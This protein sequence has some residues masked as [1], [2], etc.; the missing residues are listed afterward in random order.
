MPHESVALALNAQARAS[1]LG[2]QSMAA[3]CRAHL[4][5]C[6]GPL[7]G[8]SPALAEGRRRSVVGAV[9]SAAPG[10]FADSAAA[11]LIGMLWAADTSHPQLVKLAHRHIELC[12]QQPQQLDEDLQR[13]GLGR[14]QMPI[15]WNP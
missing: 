8:G 2:V 4:L 9:A 11:L 13:R 6:A 14:V 5:C 3:G 15:P 7:R 1:V 10:P 12:H